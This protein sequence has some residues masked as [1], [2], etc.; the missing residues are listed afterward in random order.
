MEVSK[1][2]HAHR[3]QLA[4]DKRCHFSASFQLRVRLTCF[5]ARQIHPF[6]N[7]RDPTPQRT[8]T[9]KV[10]TTC[11][12]NSHVRRNHPRRV[13]VNLQRRDSR[14]RRD[15]FLKT[16]SASVFRPS[17]FHR[18]RIRTSHHVVRVNVNN[19]SRRIVLTNLRRTPLSVNQAN[20]KFRNF[21]NREV[22]ESG[23]VAPRLCHLIRRLF[24]SIRTGGY[25][26]DQLVRVTCLRAYVIGTLLR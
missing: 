6:T 22:V 13:N 11:H 4:R 23:R 12:S 3:H 2:R 17:R 9:A 1:G 5:T 10:V 26:N 18:A 21:G 19:V 25:A 16:R 20:R 24:N 7:A 14:L 15:A 8:R